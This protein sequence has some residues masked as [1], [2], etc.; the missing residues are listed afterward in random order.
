MADSWVVGSDP[1]SQEPEKDLMWKIVAFFFVCG[2]DSFRCLWCV[3]STFLGISLLRGL[4]PSV[5][6]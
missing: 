6:P 4:D 2:V 3:V 1:F 5:C